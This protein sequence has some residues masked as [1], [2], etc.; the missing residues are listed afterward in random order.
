MTRAM[1]GRWL[2]LLLVVV[3]V[4][5]GARATDDAGKSCTPEFGPAAPWLGG[6]VASSIPLPDGRQ[7]WLFG[8]TLYG[9]KRVVHGDDPQMVNNSVAASTCQGGK[10]EIRYTLR[11]AP[12]G[13]FVSFFA[14]RQAKTWYWPIDGVYYEGELWVTL[15]CERAVRRAN[16]F[17]LGFEACGA[18]LA[19]ISGVGDP[20]PQ[21]WK[22]EYLPLVPDGVQSYPTATIVAHEGHLYIFSLN[23]FAERPLVAT[24]IPVAG[25]KEPRKH[26]QYLAADGSW[27]PGFDPKKAKAV[28]AK[29]ASELS[30]RYHPERKKWV[31][32]MMRPE[33][34][35]DAIVVRTAGDLVGPWREGETVFRV[36]ERKADALGYDGDVL[37]YAAKEHPEYETGDL[38]FSYVCNSLKPS[39]LVPLTHIYYPRM[40]RRPWPEAK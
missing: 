33:H 3:A 35:S 22:I 13:N 10:W 30:I 14:P 6:D 15:L 11:R 37:C 27:K 31:A 34:A 20:D 5:L 8:D 12:D 2:E 25:L 39:K 17:A 16:A 28:M 36:P 29:G 1:V 24:R 38:V 4:S 9:D 40:V 19:R 21:N 32:V 18:D 7:V 26:L 23:E